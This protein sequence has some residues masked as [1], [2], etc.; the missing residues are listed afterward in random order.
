MRRRSRR[1]V[2][3]NAKI[4]VKPVASEK[5][6][7]S[8]LAVVESGEVDAGVVYVTDV[9]SAGSKVKGIA[10]PGRVNASTE[11]PIAALK[12]GA[13]TPTLAKAFVAPASL[14]AAGKKVLAADGFK[15]LVTGTRARAR[16]AAGLG[17]PALVVPPALLGVLFLLLP[18]L[19][20][21]VRMPWRDLG[22]HLPRPSICGRRCGSRSSPRSR[23]PRSRSCSACR[24]PGCS[25]GCGCRASGVAARGRHASRSSCRR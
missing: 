25:P 16:R 1:K 8:T 11:Y 7:K 10:D 15:H 23:P 24:W 21:V 6:V 9:R 12:N 5:D 4:T 13:R 2:F 14:S 19:A 18:T 20:L 17:T 3:D 22:P